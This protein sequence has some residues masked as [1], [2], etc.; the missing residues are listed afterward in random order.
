MQTLQ[1]PG[2]LTLGPDGSFFLVAFDATVRAE[3]QDVSL[4]ALSKEVVAQY[5]VPVDF[6]TSDDPQLQHA[7]TFRRVIQAGVYDEQTK[8]ADLVVDGTFQVFLTGGF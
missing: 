7:A 1:T 4:L 8:S 5:R 2:T 3:A 6:V